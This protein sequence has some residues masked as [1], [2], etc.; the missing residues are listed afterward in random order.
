MYWVSFS[1]A[2]KRKPA[3]EREFKLLRGAHAC[4]KCPHPL[5]LEIP[6]LES[7]ASLRRLEQWLHGF[8]RCCRQGASC[9]CLPCHPIDLRY[10]NLARRVICIAA[11]C[12]GKRTRL[13]SRTRNVGSP[14]REGEVVSQLPSPVYVILGIQEIRRG[15]GVKPG[16]TCKDSV[17][18]PGYSRIADRG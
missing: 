14:R 10:Q 2:E 4:L 11:R 13:G 12:G 7:P 6:P 9:G 3:G 15:V 5:R 16:P 8:S 18:I 1:V 17:A